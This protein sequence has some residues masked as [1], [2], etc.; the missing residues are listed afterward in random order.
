MAIGLCAGLG[1]AVLFGLMFPPT[2]LAWLAP[3]A[4]APVIGVGL[5]AARDRGAAWDRVRGVEAGGAEAAWRRGRP[6][7]GAVGLG[8]LVGA[9]PMWAVH[10]VW[11]WGVTAAGYV[12]LVLILSLYTAG[13]VWLMALGAGGLRLAG[14]RGAALNRWLLVAAPVL[15]TG[16]EFLRGE[17]IADGYP[18]FLLGHPALDAPAVGPW[19]AATAGQYGVTLGLAA[20]G[21]LAAWA[22]LG[23]GRGGAGVLRVSAGV[24]AVGLSVVWLVAE[25]VAKQLP[26]AAIDGSVA[27][28]AAGLDGEARP[29]GRAVRVAVVQTNVPQSNKM[30]WSAEQRVRDYLRF[31]DLTVRA[32]ARAHMV[33][34]P[35]TMFPAGSLDAAAVAVWLDEERRAGTARGGSLNTALPA[36]LL[37]VQETLGVPLLIGGMGFD[38]FRFEPAADDANVR[39]PAW[40]GQYNSVFVVDEG[41]VSLRYD[42]VHLT[43][44]GEVMPYISEVDWLEEALL[45]LGAGGMTFDLDRGLRR[46]ALAVRMPSFAPAGAPERLIAATPICFEMTNAGLVRDLTFGAGGER[47]AGVIVQLTNDGWFGEWTAGKLHHLLLARWRA[48]ESG[49]P[50]VRSS[51]T[52]VSAFISERGVVERYLPS[53][54]EGV[55]SGWVTPAEG[56]AP[57]GARF[58]SAWGAGSAIAAVLLGVLGLGNFL[59]ERKAARRSMTSE[60]PPSD[61][62]RSDDGGGNGGERT[63]R[64]D[65]AE[66][67]RKS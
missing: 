9:A 23:S 66:H 60:G 39:V 14:L 12:P 24:A 30:E 28:S 53:D 3:M 54:A 61:D 34:W 55:L 29:N 46:E 48:A 49:T 16:L 10:H 59:I 42:K 56:R 36:D 4:G 6:R 21:T 65:A 1:Y 20:T 31:R 40:D 32:A 41:S 7:V 58:G 43:P 2:G 67:G 11:I 50:V 22:A 26:E 18:W 33:V 45:S 51:N 8:V 13:L 27:A 38:G 35:E 37:S 63:E 19:L 25:P 52:G 15:Y 44:F 64:T 5:W 57:W 17:V 62:E 47:E